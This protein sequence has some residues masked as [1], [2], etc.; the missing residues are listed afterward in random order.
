MFIALAILFPM[1]FHAVGLGIA[2]IPMFWP[3]AAAS[4]LL[5]TALA[6]S[7]GILAPLL[8]SLLTGMPPISPPILYLMIIELALLT[9]AIS[10][11]YHSTRLGLVWILL[12]SLCLSRLVSFFLVAVVAPLLGLPGKIFSAGLIAQGLPGVIAII[13]IVPVAINRLKNEPLV[14]S[15]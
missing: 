12:I 6:V 1:L 14:K 4:F 13:I 2:F 7:V 8:S 11:L 9:G 10:S 3:L 5:P 15:R